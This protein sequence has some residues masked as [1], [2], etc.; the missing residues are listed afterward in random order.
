MKK[1]AL[2]SVFMALPIFAQV[3][4]PNTLLVVGEANNYQ[5]P[6]HPAPF[7]GYDFL[8]N[9]Q[10]SMFPT[11]FGFEYEGWIDTAGK[12]AYAGTGTARIYVWQHTRFG[13]YGGLQFGVA[14]GSSSISSALQMGGG[15]EVQIGHYDPLKTAR[16]KAFIEPQ[17]QRI[18]ALSNPDGNSGFK[19]ALKVGVSYSF[20]RPQ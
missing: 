13:V 8:A 14:G 20:T 12:P 7:I 2:L 4:A 3:S 18:P 6:Y 11:Y 16:W 15:G 5:A 17:A 1:L 19:P 9:A 10:A